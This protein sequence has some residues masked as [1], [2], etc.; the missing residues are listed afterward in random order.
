MQKISLLV[1]LLSAGLHA[2]A[3]EIQGMFNRQKSFTIES[4]R[5]TPQKGL[6][7]ALLSTSTKRPRHNFRQSCQLIGPV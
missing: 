2:S 5:V 6:V 3:S 4:L 7:S 1:F